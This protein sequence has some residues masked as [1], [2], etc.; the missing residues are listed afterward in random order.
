MFKHRL[1][2]IGFLLCQ[3]PAIGSLVILMIQMGVWKLTG[4]NQAV[5]AQSELVP[6]DLESR[7]N[8][9]S[10][11]FFINPV[12]QTCAWPEPCH[13]FVIDETGVT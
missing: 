3:A 2:I 9:F 7:A 11:L 10:V 4:G 1:G 13:P 5:A 8:P 12:S 6:F